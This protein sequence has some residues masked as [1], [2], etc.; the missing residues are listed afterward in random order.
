MNKTVNINLAGTF[1]HIDEDAYQKLQRYL[2]AI[3]R[4]FTDSQG[5]NEIIADIET[6]IAELF[7]ERVENDKQVVSTKEVD[8]VITIM[9]QPEDYIV[10]E[11]IFEDEPKQSYKSSRTDT[12][13]KLYRDTE[14]AYIGGVSSGLSHYFGIEPLWIRLIWVLLFFGAGTGILVYI[15][16]W[17][18]M[19]AA[20]TTS[21]K[22]AMSGKPV[23]I[24]NIE[25][26]VKEGF[27]NV[28][29][30]LDGVADRISNADYD[31]VS[32]KVKHKS[33]SFFDA[34]G[35]VIMFF[36]K[37]FAKFIGIILIIVGA[38]T[39]ISLIVSLLSVG[40]V[41]IFNFDGIDMA[42]TFYSSNLPIWVVSLLV[43]FAVG[44][45]FFF[46][47]ILG[48]KILVD[49]LKSLGRT[50]NFTLFGLWL[51][52]IV[53]LAIFAAREV[54][55][56]SREGEFT[57]TI[58][59]NIK[60]ND[61]LFVEMVNNEKYASNNYRNNDFDI[62]FDDNNKKQIYSSDV[63]FLVKSTKDS[64]AYMEIVKDARGR[65]YQDARDRAEEIDYNFDYS[66]GK[67]KLD[68]YFLTDA[69]NKFRDQDVTI[70]VFMPEGS[71]IYSD[72]STRNQRSWRYGSD[73]IS[74]GKENHFLKIKYNDIECL[75]CEKEDS[76][77]EIKDDE[78][79]L[80]IDSEKI[81]YKDGEVKA[82]IDSSGIT[83]KSTDN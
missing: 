8:E 37:I 27:S 55:E 83:I 41:D 47:F 23:N 67:L 80:E 63:R 22:L 13:R 11:E 78:G 25:E 51:A 77:I 64:I 7:N 1:F 38:T 76:I 58:E 3:K 68:N 43:L 48:L 35:N 17:I 74:R 52:S 32:N 46:I 6:R 66:D 26:K 65:T 54:A 16:L 30:S 75:D 34:L 19:P 20:E 72:K 73:I 10:D 15:L 39:L 40:V 36:F 59:L 4:S 71:V 79:S 9:G 5:R 44:I 31:G 81:E 82:T 50:A 61:T 33:R 2:E 49:N 45:P 28:K 18:L 56:F 62:V 24:T 70:T 69:D 29:E 42:H 57:N 53:T 60:A 12:T 14:N 21:E